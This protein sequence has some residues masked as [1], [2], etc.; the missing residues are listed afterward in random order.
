[1]TVWNLLWKFSAGSLSTSTDTSRSFRQYLRSSSMVLYCAT[2]GGR[3]SC[4][5]ACAAEGGR[6][7]HE[8][9][10]AGLVVVEEVAAVQDEVGLRPPRGQRRSPASRRRECEHR[11]H[12]LIGGDLEH[13]LEGLERVRAADLVLLVVADVVVRGHQDLQDVL[14][15]RR[16]VVPHRQPA[17]SGPP[18]HVSSASPLRCGASSPRC[19]PP[20]RVQAVA[21]RR[22]GPPAAGNPLLPALAS[23]R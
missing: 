21:H 18:S 3:L 5:C 6:E 1:M 7:A 15:P 20:P 23:L 17:R 4:S 2:P 9:A 19:A 8:R 16:A 22:S 13:L 12:L 11:T 10:A 14:G